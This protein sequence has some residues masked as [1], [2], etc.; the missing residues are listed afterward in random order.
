MNLQPDSL[1]L[2][3]SPVAKVSGPKPPR[4]EGGERFLK[5]PIPWAWLQRAANLPGHALHVGIYLWWLAG[6]KN[7]AA[8]TVSVGTLDKELGVKRHTAGR[9]LTSLSEAGLVHSDR[10]P[11]RKPRITL[12]SGRS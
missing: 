5:G 11:G 4:H 6:M 12:L 2:T 3:E 10:R 8:I 7:T 1:R 9:A